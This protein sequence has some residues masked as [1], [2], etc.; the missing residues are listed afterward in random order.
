MFFNPPAPIERKRIRELAHKGSFARI[1]ELSYITRVGAARRSISA[2][3]ACRYFRLAAAQFAGYLRVLYSVSRID[4][5]EGH[6]RCLRLKFFYI[7]RAR[8][9]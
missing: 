5:G 4:A 9:R 8:T 7:R 2:I 3:F 6:T 1:T